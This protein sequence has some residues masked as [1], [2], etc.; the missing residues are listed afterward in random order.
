MSE[1][2]KGLNGLNRKAPGHGSRSKPQS[3]GVGIPTEDLQQKTRNGVTKLGSQL[4]EKMTNH[5][6]VH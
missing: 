4:R 6:V 5:T 3:P 2:K 1:F